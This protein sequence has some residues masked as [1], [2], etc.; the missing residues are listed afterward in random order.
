MQANRTALGVDFEASAAEIQLDSGI[1]FG[2]QLNSARVKRHYKTFACTLLSE[3]FAFNQQPFS[4]LLLW[5][6]KWHE[7]TNAMELSKAFKN[8]L[9][10]E[11]K[12]GSLFN[13]KS[14]GEVV[15]LKKSFEEER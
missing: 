3:V 1:T 2:L 7:V 14:F 4:K 11:L 12:F 15:K 13:K 10:F 6:T 5:T 9:A 8:S